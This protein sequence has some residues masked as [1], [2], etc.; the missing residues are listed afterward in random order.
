MV[1]NITSRKF[2]TM[3]FLNSMFVYW[4]MIIQRKHKGELNKDLFTKV[5]RWTVVTGLTT[6]A[7]SLAAHRYN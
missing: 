6:S 2:K 3:L 5:D 4:V 7:N 1:L